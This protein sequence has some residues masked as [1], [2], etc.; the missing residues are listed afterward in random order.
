MSDFDFLLNSTK[1][2]AYGIYAIRRPNIPIPKKRVESVKVPYVE[3]SYTYDED[4]YDDIKFSIECNFM[5]KTPETFAEESRRAAKWCNTNSSLNSYISLSF[6]DDSD[7]FYK[8]KIT[9][10]SDIERTSPRIGVFTIDVICEPFPYHVSGN[11]FLTATDGTKFTN[12][13]TNYYKSYPVYVLKGT[14]SFGIN[15]NDDPLL[16]YDFN[17]TVDGTATIDTKELL[18]YDSDGTSLIGNT[19]KGSIISSSAIGDIVGLRFS[20]KE[21]TVYLKIPEGGSVQIQPN[22]R[23][24]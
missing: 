13:A 4:V 1:A 15:I 20:S 18:V 8:I 2:S 6:T 3:G 12:P 19:S 22:W 11:Q 24:F 17:I 5:S 14:G 10:V 7:Y 21:N 9:T 16:I 23:A